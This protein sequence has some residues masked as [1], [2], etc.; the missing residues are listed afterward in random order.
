MGAE[1]W[2]A[3]LEQWEESLELKGSESVS[4]LIKCFTTP[5]LEMNMLQH[6]AAGIVVFIFAMTIWLALDRLLRK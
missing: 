3:E 4:W 1:G 2:A 5:Y 6:L